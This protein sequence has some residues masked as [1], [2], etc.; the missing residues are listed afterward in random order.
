MRQIL[1]D[2]LDDIQDKR[3]EQA[4]YTKEDFFDLI[5]ETIEEYREEGLITDDE[6]TESMRQK[7]RA[8]WED[9]NY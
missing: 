2:I 5:E 8:C 7:L 9:I 4:A 3:E 6:D 1:S